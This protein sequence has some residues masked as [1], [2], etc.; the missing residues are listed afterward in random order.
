ME[1]KI[2]KNR[3]IFDIKKK[4]IFHRIIICKNTLMV[5]NYIY[6]N[7]FFYCNISEDKFL[8]N[9]VSLTELKTT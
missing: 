8:C 1:T 7:T 6:M 3:I 4:R 5:F 9:T 2:I